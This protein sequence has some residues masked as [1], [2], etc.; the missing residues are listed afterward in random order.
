MGN[1]ADVSDAL[2]AAR[3]ENMSGL[4]DGESSMLSTWIRRANAQF[5]SGS[6]VAQAFQS[7]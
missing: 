5:T 2:V 6:A 4:L 7:N 3:L 1:N